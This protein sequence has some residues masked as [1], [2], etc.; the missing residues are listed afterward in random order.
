M[1]IRF[2]EWDSSFFNCQIYLLL[3]PEC[4]VSLSDLKVQLQQLN[5]D[6]VYI[7]SS[8]RMEKFENELYQQGGSLK[9]IKITYIKHLGETPVNCSPM[10][11]DYSGEVNSSLI[12]LA[13]EAGQ[14]SRFREDARLSLDFERF[15]RTWIENSVNKSIADKV[16]TISSENQI[17]GMITCKVE[18]DEGRIG[19]I[20]VDSEQRGLGLGRKLINCVENFYAS[21]K[22][23]NSVVATQQANKNACVFYETCGYHI[24]KKE[25]IYHWWI[26]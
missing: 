9:D 1:E 5:A 24:F 19:L 8:S 11:E 18:K 3:Q 10:A 16:F 13:L 21:Q 12:K 15:Y 22:I 23:Y 2:M 6:L 7:I 25:Y 26:N 20:S 14:Y 4:G 17:A